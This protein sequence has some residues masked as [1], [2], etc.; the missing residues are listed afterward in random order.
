MNRREGQRE[1]GWTATGFLGAA[2]LGFL[3]QGC[4]MTFDSG[5]APDPVVDEVEPNDGACCAQFVGVLAPDDRLEIDG[6]VTATGPDQFDG[7]AFAADQ[8]CEVRIALIADD[9]LADLDV[10]VFDP[11]LGDFT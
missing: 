8:P 1:I 4:T 7:F 10:C 2:A 6:F 3:L 11:Q 5:P 9:P